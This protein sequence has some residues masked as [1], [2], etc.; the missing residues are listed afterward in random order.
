MKR[1]WS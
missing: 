1:P